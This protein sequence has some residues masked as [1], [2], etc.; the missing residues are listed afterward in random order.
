MDTI[1]LHIQAAPSNALWI[2]KREDTRGKASEC[3]LG[4][5]GIHGNRFSLGAR[6]FPVTE[7]AFAAPLSF[8]GA[9]TFSLFSLLD[10]Y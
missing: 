7:L 8:S 1:L 9:L 4:F 5:E 10:G 6:C 3:Y 2:H